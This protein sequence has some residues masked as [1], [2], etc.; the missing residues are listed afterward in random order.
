MGIATLM[1]DVFGERPL[2]PDHVAATRA[3]VALRRL[4][5]GAEM[6]PSDRT[7]LRDLTER[8]RQVSEFVRYYETEGKEGEV[9]PVDEFAAIESLATATT[10]SDRPVHVIVQALPDWEP[11]EAGDTR[12]SAKELL[13]VMEGWAAALGASAG[14]VGLRE[15]AEPSTDAAA[16]AKW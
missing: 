7:A 6:R 3:V 12:D 10:R 1:E 4:L 13:T 15:P 16:M 5:R 9:P 11:D 8:L 2:P 14:R